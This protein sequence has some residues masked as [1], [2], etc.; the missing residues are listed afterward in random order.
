M[1]GVFPSPNAK[2]ISFSTKWNNH[3]QIP[4]IST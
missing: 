1:F 4:T 3:E 2:L